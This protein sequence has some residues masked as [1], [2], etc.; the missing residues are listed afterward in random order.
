MARPCAHCVAPHRWLTRRGAPAPARPGG[1]DAD[2]SDAAMSTG[3]GDEEMLSPGGSGPDVA[4][5][6]A[7]LEAAPEAVDLRARPA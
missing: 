4:A 5:L 1:A 3:D 2:G 6:G 7:A